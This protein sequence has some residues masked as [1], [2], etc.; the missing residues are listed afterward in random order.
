MKY[1]VRRTV[2]AVLLLCLLFSVKKFPSC[3]D[4]LLHN[5]GTAS[6]V[7]TSEA[8]DPAEEYAQ[9]QIPEY[10]GE[11]YADVNDDIPFFTEDEITSEAFEYY[12]ELDELGR[13]TVALACVG[14]ETLPTEKRGPI[15]MI[16]P[17]GWHTVKYDI[18]DHKYLYN[19][20]HLIG[21]QLTGENANERNLITGTRYMNVEGMLPFEN[22]VREYV[23]GTGN[24][25]MYRVT[26]CFDGDDLLAR[27][28]LMEAK[29]VED[30][31]VQFCVFVFNIQPGIGIDYSTGDNWLE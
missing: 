21:F 14:P 22:S 12:G 8:E 31:A 19:R 7:E 13:C 29:S 27:G 18:V 4:G 17:T 26:P 24:H 2:S 15:G 20:C 9:F 1:F 3:F 16:K 30:P 28:V 5:A 11:P 10:T 25:V 23:T 6:A